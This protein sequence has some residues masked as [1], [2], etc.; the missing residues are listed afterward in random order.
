MCVTW[1]AMRPLTA[2]GRRG[3][4]FQPAALA[5]ITPGDAAILLGRGIRTICDLRSGDERLAAPND[6]AAAPSIE[7]WARP[8]TEV[9]GDS[10]ELPLQELPGFRRGRGRL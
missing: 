1:A 8:A 9:V 3:Q 2:A 5:D 7:F 10:G 4:V 6:W